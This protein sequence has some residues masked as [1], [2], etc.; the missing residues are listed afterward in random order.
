MRLQR[1]AFRIDIERSRLVSS[2][3]FYEQSQG[4]DRAQRLALPELGKVAPHA[5]SHNQRRRIPRKRHALP[6]HSDDH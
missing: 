6:T 1:Q 4:I 3:A 5:T 2:V